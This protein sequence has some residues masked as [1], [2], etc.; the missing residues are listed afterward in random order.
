MTDMDTVNAAVK[1]KGEEG[2]E[3]ESEICTA[4]RRSP[5]SSQIKRSFQ[6]I[7]QNKCQLCKKM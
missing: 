4:V 6:T 3:D 1:Q 5:N 7:S 2:G